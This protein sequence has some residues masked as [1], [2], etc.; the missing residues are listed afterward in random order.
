MTCPSTAGL[1]SEQTEHS[2][3]TLSWPQWPVP[4]RLD[5]TTRLIVIVIIG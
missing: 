5:A 3:R 4:S 1:S 2:L